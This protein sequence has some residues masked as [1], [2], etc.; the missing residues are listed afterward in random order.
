MHM[1]T[2]E[3]HLDYLNMQ[4][5]VILI[6]TILYRFPKKVLFYFLKL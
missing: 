5:K 1:R 4:L 3:L 6:L 2:S